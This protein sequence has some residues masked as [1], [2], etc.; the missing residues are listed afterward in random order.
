MQDGILKKKKYFHFF[1]LQF[2]ATSHI[3]EKRQIPQTTRNVIT[4]I[5]RIFRVFLV[6]FSLIPT[7]ID[8]IYRSMMKFER[9]NIF[10]FCFSL[11]ICDFS[12]TKSNNLE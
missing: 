12:A 3:G 8:M 9:T 11:P 5:R 10:F 1:L 4:P 2:V 6:Q 7:R